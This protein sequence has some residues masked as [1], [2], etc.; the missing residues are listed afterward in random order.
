[1]NRAMAEIFGF[2]N[3]LAAV[4]IIGAGGVIGHQL[5]RYYYAFSLIPAPLS[6]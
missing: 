3:A 6:G 4:V 5:S 1:M 2:I